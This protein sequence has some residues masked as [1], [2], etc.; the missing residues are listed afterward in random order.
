MP[1]QKFRVE[2]DRG[3]FE[4]EV[5]VADPQQ[6]KNEA[7]KAA[8]A[9]PLKE[10]T[11]KTGGI[12]KGLNS[13]ADELGR[14]GLEGMAHPKSAGDFLGLMLPGSRI[15]GLK[16]T[17]AVPG[18]VEPIGNTALRAGARGA[19]NVLD[20]TPNLIRSKA[21]NRIVD[22]LR[23]AGGPPTKFN[24]LP[25]VK[26][27]NFFPETPAPSPMRKIAA[28]P[29]RPETPFHERPLYQQMEDLSAPV[30]N[31]AADPRGG[32]P[33]ASGRE[34]VRRSPS[35]VRIIGKAPSLEE[36]LN[37]ALT[38]EMG[39]QPAGSA[40]LPPEPSITPGGATHQSGQFGRSQKVGQ[41]GGY[42]SGR[43]A[44]SETRY[45]EMTGNLGGEGAGTPPD[46]AIPPSS[47]APS[48][49]ADLMDPATIQEEVRMSGTRG[50]A[51][52]LGMTVEEVE[53]ALGGTNRQLPLEAEQ[54]MQDARGRAA[55]MTDTSSGLE[56]LLR[57][58]LEARGGQP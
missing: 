2:T 12:L 43:P 54:R 24:D 10:P 36:V 56:G 53:A 44:V 19:A 17:A 25:L 3:N 9:K 5:E 18:T 31:P 41:P 52:R 8:N 55:T 11:T 29:M 49:P 6:A 38:A 21:E 51:A 27:E 35:D 30:H 14:A 37:E 26:Q 50:A 42:T 48:S 16:A 22:A 28:P 58:I 23:E 20:F 46:A 45:Q 15:P 40:S 57:Q 39:G 34:N 4:V 47:G 33:I 32:G 13:Y 7:L 1:V